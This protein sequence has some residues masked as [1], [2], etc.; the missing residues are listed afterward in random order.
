[1][2]DN[3]G[4]LFKLIDDGTIR[5]NKGAI[6]TITPPPLSD[7]FIFERI[8]GM[9]LGAAIGDSL[10]ATSEGITG[11]E[12]LSR[13]GEIRDYLPWRRSANK[14]VGV[15]TDDTQLTFWTLKQLLEDHG[16]VPDN[17]AKRFCRHHISGIGSTT[18]AFIGNY[19]T[20]H[21]PWY[22][23]GE[24]SLG[25]GALM[26]IS[27]I[28]VPYLRN[29]H[30]SMYADAALDSMITHNSYANNATCIAFVAML[31]QLISMNKAPIPLW[32]AETFSNLSK[33]L[34]G[35][36]GYS[37]EKKTHY[38]YKGS[39]WRYVEMVVNDA[40]KNAHSSLEACERWGSG[41]RLLETVPSVLYI[42]AKYSHDPEE[43]I[44][45]AVNDT[46][47]NDTIGSIVGAAVGA[48]HGVD[49][50]PDRWI[51]GLTGRTRAGIDDSG[52]VFKLILLAKKRFWTSN[53][54]NV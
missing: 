23:S 24:N 19:T 12:R 27:P 26:R 14:P 46:W 51:R 53:S 48:L 5:L 6:L 17:L 8:E 29:P 42:L 21:K 44:V 15:P 47:D 49:G 36:T 54:A 45:R 32:W 30:H 38:S 18:R 13:H 25:N 50:I 16:L 41:A 3:T 1:M 2:I 4:L 35:D 33:D 43:A 52:E 22:L 31:W 40:L 37:V 28:V 7:K 20:K 34:E 39:L 11:R 10:G 9:L